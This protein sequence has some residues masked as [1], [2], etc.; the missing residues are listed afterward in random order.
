MGYS[1]PVHRC[2]RVQH[3]VLLPGA[4]HDPEGHGELAA[5][6]VRHM[7]NPM[8][9][10]AGVSDADNRLLTHEEARS[11]GAPDS[12]LSILAHWLATY[13]VN[14]HADLGRTGS[15]CPFVRQSSRLD[16]LRL[17]ISPAGPD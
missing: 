14:G 5:Q 10:T 12:P 13:P 7:W 6:T 15:V 1:V 8:L 9:D 17:A 11:T 3:P 16:V 2:S 4:I